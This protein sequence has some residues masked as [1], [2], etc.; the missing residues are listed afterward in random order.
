MT[1]HKS[2]LSPEDLRA[3]VREHEPDLLHFCQFGD[4]GPGSVNLDPDV[5]AGSRSEPKPPRYPWGAD[6]YV[7]L[8]VT[9]RLQ[10]AIRSMPAKVVDGRNRPC[11]RQILTTRYGER[12]FKWDDSAPADSERWLVEAQRVYCEAARRVPRC[13]RKPENYP[14]AEESALRGRVRICEGEDEDV[15]V[16]TGFPEDSP[17]VKFGFAEGPEGRVPGGGTVEPGTFWRPRCS[18]CSCY[19]DQCTCRRFW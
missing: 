6:L 3:W 13:R 8:T 4:I 15:Q 5:N 16:V 12:G 11:V 2:Y 9:E 19:V 17:K 7:I 10:E 18:V 14:E 1:N